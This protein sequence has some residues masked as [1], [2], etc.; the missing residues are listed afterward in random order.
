MVTEPGAGAGEVAGPTHPREPRPG[1]I[2]LEEIRWFPMSARTLIRTYH[3]WIG[4]ARDGRWARAAAALAIRLATSD[5]GARPSAVISCGPPHM[6]HEAA[7]RVAEA[8]E[9]PSIMDLRDP[10]SLTPRLPESSASPLWYH[11]ARYH[12]SRAVARSTLVVANTE[13]VRQAM[14]A[15]YPEASDRII[16]VMN[17]FDDDPIPESVPGSRFLIAYAGVIYVDRN[18]RILFR[19]A[20]RLIREFGLGPADF[21]IEFIGQVAELNGVSLESIAAEEGVD[22]FVRLYPP[23]PR[24]EAL[25]FLAHAAMLINLPQSID[26]SIPSKIFD[27]MRFNAWLLALSARGSAPELLLRDTSADLV[28]PDD[29]EGLV[30]RLRERYRQHLAGQRP[31]PIAAEAPHLSR[32]AQASHLFDMIERH[33]G[34]P[35]AERSLPRPVAHGTPGAPPRV[36]VNPAGP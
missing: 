18:P 21:G 5:H 2:G 20:A 4:F 16:T 27:Y 24:H 1:D 35:G 26:M 7:R 13:Q 19:A 25:E 14:R 28:E 29:L 31:P 15:R 8:L 6:V 9:I 32:R 22:D 23:V 36:R 12:E 10:W 11:L 34:A 33:L 17:G 3:A 30:A